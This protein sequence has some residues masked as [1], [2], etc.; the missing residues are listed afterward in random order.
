MGKKEDRKK[1]LKEWFEEQD[2]WKTIKEISKDPSIPYIPYNTLKKHF[3]LGRMPS[4]QNREKLYRITKLKCFESEERKPTEPISIQIEPEVEK[5]I[6]FP[7]RTMV[8][9]IVPSLDNLLKKIGDDIAQRNK[10]RASVQRIREAWFKE[11]F[12]SAGRVIS[13]KNIQSLSRFYPE[14]EI[15]VEKIKMCLEQ[16]IDEKIDRIEM[17]LKKY[18]DDRQIKLHGKSPKFI[19]DYLINL[20]LN[21]KKNTAKIENIYLQSLDWGKIQE[22]IE[23]ERKRVWERPFDYSKFYDDVIL[24]YE[25]I[26]DYERNPTGWVRLA[27]IYQ[28]LKTEIAKRNPDWKSK[29]RLVAYYKDEFSADLSK[30]WKAQNS[31]DRTDRQFE[32]SAIRDPRLA[33]KVILPDRSTA[34]YGFIRPKRR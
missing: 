33:F 14:G 17:Q 8:Q 19:I 21:R 29:K 32:F 15:T 25:K 11:N 24:F 9:T 10:I 30:A 18:C 28:L 3:S 31:D 22:S 23:E 20:E 6:P 7:P 16:E 12:D 2:K 5:P 34:S 4:P 26:A 1:A 13:S 27:D